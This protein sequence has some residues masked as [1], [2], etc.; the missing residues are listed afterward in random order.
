M[1]KLYLFDD[2]QIPIVIHYVK[3]VIFKTWNETWSAAARPALPTIH[4]YQ[5]PHPIISCNVL[6]NSI[7]STIHPT[8]SHFTQTHFIPENLKSDSKNKR[9]YINTK[10]INM[11]TDGE[12]I[13]L[14][15]K[16]QAALP[17]ARSQN[18]KVSTD[19]VLQ[20]AC[21]NI[22]NLQKEVGDLSEKISQLFR[23]WEMSSNAG[24]DLAISKHDA[25]GV[26]QPQWWD[27]GF[28]KP[29]PHLGVPFSVLR[30]LVPVT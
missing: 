10:N 6:I 28:E 20:D 12:I 4:I 15:S 16:L 17:E 23:T 7:S 5:F 11:S 8:P 18:G 21:D 26:P 13:H 3:I 22:N 25:G 2:S 24:T 1:H 27:L 19:K 9:I 14:L 29:Q 30:L